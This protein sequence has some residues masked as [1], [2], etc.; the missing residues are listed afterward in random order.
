M[1]PSVKPSVMPFFLHTSKL[2]LWISHH[3]LSDTIL[4]LYFRELDAL[5]VDPGFHGL[6]N[7][8]WDEEVN[9]M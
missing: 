4:T 5:G 8:V 7:L 2:S 9:A 3:K 6:E 1:K